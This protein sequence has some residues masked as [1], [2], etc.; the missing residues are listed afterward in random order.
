MFR[1]CVFLMVRPNL[2]EPGPRELL[3]LVPV[4]PV[5]RSV[6]AAPGS[7][8]N[9]TLCVLGVAEDDILGTLPQTHL[10]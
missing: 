8:K 7:P 5:F 10:A 9:R 6:A 1:Y 2:C 4:G 3:T